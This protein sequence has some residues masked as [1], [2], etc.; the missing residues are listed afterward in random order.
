MTV[1]IARSLAKASTGRKVKPI[2]RVSFRKPRK[3]RRTVKP[4][5]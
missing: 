1:H 3:P 2:T 4:V 5:P